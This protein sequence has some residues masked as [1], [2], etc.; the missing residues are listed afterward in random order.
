RTRLPRSVLHRH[1]AGL[2]RHDRGHRECRGPTG[3]YLR[4]VSKGLALMGGAWMALAVVWVPLAFQ[5]ALGPS[6]PRLTVGGGP[7]V[8]GAAILITAIQRL[9]RQH[10]PQGVTA[11]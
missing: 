6:R 11:S 9:R 2:H 10:Q 1:R 7:F 4:R 8:V 5:L 3:G